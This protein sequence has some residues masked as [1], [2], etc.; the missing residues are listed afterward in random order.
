MIESTCCRYDGT[1]RQQAWYVI[2]FLVGM[3]FIIIY[4]SF[5]WGL[6]L[7]LTQLLS[8]SA[9]DKLVIFFIFIFFFFFF[10]FFFF[11]FLERQFA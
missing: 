5:K 1:D 6:L 9:D 8:D 11:C 2:V 3:I 10:F 7:T 4:M